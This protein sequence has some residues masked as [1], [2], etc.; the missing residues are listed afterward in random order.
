MSG[1]SVAA[2]SA[3]V[4]I[5]GNF[6]LGLNFV[7]VKLYPMRPG[8]SVC[9]AHTATYDGYCG[10]SWLPQVPLR[11]VNG[12]VFFFMFVAHLAPADDACA[13]A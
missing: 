10:A 6:M 7:F 3:V 5:K 2:A 4:A 12:T 9:P 11:G 8:G 13:A 1:C